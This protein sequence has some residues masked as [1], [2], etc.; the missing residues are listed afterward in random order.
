MEK[1]DHDLT[2]STNQEENTDGSKISSN[3]Y[4][5]PEDTKENQALKQKSDCIVGHN[6]S[7]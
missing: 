5:S 6:A 7:S 4:F 1:Q 3:E 2:V